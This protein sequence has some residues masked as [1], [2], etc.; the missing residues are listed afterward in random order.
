MKVLLLGYSSIARRRVIPA[1][2]RLGVRD[3]D[4]ASVSSDLSGAHEGFEGRKFHNYEDAL[5]A[6]NAQLV[7]ISTTNHLHASLAALSLRRGFHTV[8][9]KP[10]CLSLEEAQGVAELS[11]SAG[12]CIAEATVYSYHPQVL[13]AVDLCQG[14]ATRLLAAFSIPPLPSS[15]HRYR[16]DLAGGADLDMGPY[17]LTPARLF[18]GSH[19]LEIEGRVL[20]EHEGAITSFSLLSLHPKGRCLTGVFGFT[21]AYVNQLQ[22]LGPDIR[23]EM[24]RVF[25]PPADLALELSVRENDRV[26]SVEIAPADS[27]EQFLKAVFLSIECGEFEGFRET[28]LFDAEE[29]DALRSVLLRGRQ[30]AA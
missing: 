19:S 16:T 1:L 24:E 20:S 9:D 6:S 3:L 12:R 26:K 5:S 15:N 4:V 21:T 30:P 14:R 28:L 10:A 29:L 8:V 18:F 23:I 13:T 2:Q 17:A 25:S 27:F 7:Y 11:R 22:V